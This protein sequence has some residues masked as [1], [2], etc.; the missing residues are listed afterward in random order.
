MSGADGCQDDRD[1]HRENEGNARRKKVRARGR[2]LGRTKGEGGGQMLALRKNRSGRLVDQ[3]TRSTSRNQKRR[4]SGQTF[5]TK[6]G[7]V[8][9]MVSVAEGRDVLRDR[10][11]STNTV[12]NSNQSAANE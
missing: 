5:P 4:V 12:A 3:I 11:I 8:P 2:G 6:E 7:V 10:K 9:M 1:Q